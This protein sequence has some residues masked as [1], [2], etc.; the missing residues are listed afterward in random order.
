M[1]QAL[2]RS[3]SIARLAI[4]KNDDLC[5]QH[6][7]LQIELDDVKQSNVVLEEQNQWNS[8]ELIRLANEITTLQGINNDYAMQIDELQ[9]ELD[10]KQ[11]PNQ[12]DLTLRNL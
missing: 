12:N 8:D 11:L 1:E 3:C 2:A 9:Q 10:Q 5:S 4:E 6:Q 7:N